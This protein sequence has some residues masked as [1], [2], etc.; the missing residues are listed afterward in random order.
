M[1]KGGVIAF[2]EALRDNKKGEAKAM[3]EFYE[4]R[5]KV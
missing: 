2:D 1:S 4:K 3:K 5:K